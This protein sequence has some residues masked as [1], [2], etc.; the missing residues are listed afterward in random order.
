[1]ISKLLKKYQQ[2]KDCRFLKNHGCETW[3]QYHRRFDP[4]Y[5]IRATRISDYYHGY[6]YWHVFDNYKHYC[7]QFLSDHG[8]GGRRYGYDDINA[9]C[10][11][12]LAHRFRLDVL[13]VARWPRPDGEW[14]INE[15]GGEDRIFMAFKDQKEYMNFLLRWG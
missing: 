1:M 11:Q 7:Y 10:K 8:T 3:D 14:A 12:N 5:N 6:P 13:R 9:W 4:D 15:L 2:W